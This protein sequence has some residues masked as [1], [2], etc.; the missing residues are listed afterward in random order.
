MDVRVESTLWPAKFSYAFL[1]LIKA[2]R[3]FR[4]N[5]AIHSS[6]L[7]SITISSFLKIL[8]PILGGVHFFFSCP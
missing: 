7:I 3:H 8:K 5:F 4:N 1:D 2:V 6:Q